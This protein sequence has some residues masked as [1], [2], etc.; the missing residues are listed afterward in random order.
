MLDD[1][2]K[3]WDQGPPIPA[4]GGVIV[5]FRDEPD[6][7]EGRGSS[8]GPPGGADRQSLG[9][10]QDAE[11]LPRVVAWGLRRPPQ[12]DALR[13]GEKRVL[14]RHR[15]PYPWGLDLVGL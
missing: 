9:W 15:P 14:G 6:G 10:F 3:V 7:H 12:R 1:R 2:K 13:P 11:V 8:S 5:Y 4:I